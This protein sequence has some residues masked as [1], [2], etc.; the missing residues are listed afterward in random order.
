MRD[1]LTGGYP[2]PPTDKQLAEHEAMLAGKRQ[3]M[4]D[5][6]GIPVEELDAALDEGQ[7]QREQQ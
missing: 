4:A 2:F 6:R 1:D 7:R 3:R 5:E